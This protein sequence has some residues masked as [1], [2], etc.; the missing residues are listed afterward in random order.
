M[1][2]PIYYNLKTFKNCYLTD[3]EI[4]GSTSYLDYLEEMKTEYAN[5]SKLS[6]EQNPLISE[7]F[8]PDEVVFSIIPKKI[9]IKTYLKI[10]PEIDKTLSLKEQFKKI[11]EIN[12]FAILGFLSMN[13]DDILNFI[14]K[15]IKKTSLLQVNNKTHE[16]ESYNEK[17][18]GYNIPYKIA[19]LHEMKVLENLNRQFVN[20]SDVH[21]I[22]T[23]LVGG[24]FDNNVD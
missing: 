11:I 15:E 13:F 3:F 1:E 9:L 12:E 8:P 21:R 16:P 7:L 4:W 2:I 20:K 22:L 24:N 10:Y 14:E 18:R 6:A 5:L 19:L 23:F 17:E